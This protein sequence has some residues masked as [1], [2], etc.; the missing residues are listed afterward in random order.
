MLSMRSD[1][2][3]PRSA[4]GAPASL[5]LRALSDTAVEARWGDRIHVLLPD[6]PYA[7]RPQIETE[8]P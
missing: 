4:P 1:W 3:M 6:L 8:R 7:S 2:R 5:T